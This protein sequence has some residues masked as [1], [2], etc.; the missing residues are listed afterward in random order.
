MQALSLFW[1]MP[2][3]KENEKEKKAVGGDYILN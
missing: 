3:E 2:D 1:R